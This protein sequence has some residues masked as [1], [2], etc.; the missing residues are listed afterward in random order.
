[1]FQD[2]YC[3]W[4]SPS[5]AFPSGDC[6]AAIMYQSAIDSMHAGIYAGKNKK[7]EVHDCSVVRVSEEVYLTLA[8]GFPVTDRLAHGMSWASCL[9]IAY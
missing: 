9:S 2:V 6:K 5:T 4:V 8:A 3:K 7:A 1:M